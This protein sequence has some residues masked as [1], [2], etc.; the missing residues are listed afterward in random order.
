MKRALAIALVSVLALGVSPS[1]SSAAVKAGATCKK[2]GQLSK[3]AGKEYTCIKKGKK[4]VWSQ[5]VTIKTAAPAATSV[6]T[7]TPTPTPSP[8][9]ISTAIPTPTPTPVP[10]AVPLI[11]YNGPQNAAAYEAIQP[12]YKLLNQVS[13]ELA[14]RAQSAGKANVQLLSDEP[15]N[16]LVTS[17]KAV[18]IKTTEM[19]RAID[20]NFLD[21]EVYLFRDISWL[22]SSSLSTKCPHLIKNQE[23]FGWANA[24]CDKYWVGDFAF[25]EDPK[26]YIGRSRHT[27]KTLLG[28]SGSH[29]TV[30]LIQVGNRNGQ[31][32]K[33][34]AW[35]REGSAS[36]GAGLAM[37]AM[38][39]FA[40]GDYNAVDDWELNSWS[41]Q[42]CGEVFNTWKV[43]HDE[44]GH[45]AMKNC[46][47]SVGRRMIEYLVARDKSFDN[48]FK[49]YSAVGPTMTFNEAFEKYHGL[50]IDDFFA[51]VETWLD[52]VGWQTAV[53]Y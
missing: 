51:Q 50:K 35:Y 30:H 27:P 40:N 10:S 14:L 22:K 24:G 20:P 32:S 7:P 29:E 15:N 16:P 34:P 18:V 42:R 28:F 21:N 23:T 45:A 53:T 39:D 13:A 44:T 5:G 37:V 46:E 31:S 19:M 1:I 2:A 52:K 47:Y 6:P 25:Y 9:P 3:K 49:V 26:N 8:T 48:I 17:T 33:F 4:L 12:V 41:K 38:T 43:K 36:V 11:R